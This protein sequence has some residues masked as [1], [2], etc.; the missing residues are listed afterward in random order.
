MA[1][2]FDDAGKQISS[3]AYTQEFMDELEGFMSDEAF[4]VEAYLTERYLAEWE[5]MNAVHERL[6][7]ITMPRNPLY[8]PL[9]MMPAHTKLGQLVDPLSGQPVGSGSMDPSSTLRRSKTAIAEPNF[10]DAFQTFFAHKQQI[11]H[12]MAYAELVKDMQAVLGSRKLRKS[13]EARAGREGTNT[14]AGWIKI[15]AEDGIKDSAVS[16][17]PLR[18]LSNMVNRGAQMALVGRFSVMVIQQTQIMAGSLVMPVDAYVKRLALLHAGQL[19][20]AAAYNSDYI[21]RRRKAAPPAVRMAMDQMAA[22]KPNLMKYVA[23]RAGDGIGVADAVFTA[24]TYAILYDYHLSQGKLENLSDAD[25]E[26]QAHLMAEQLV[27]QVAQPVR[28]GTRS[29]FENQATNPVMKLI[30]AFS[31][32]PRQ[33]IV[34][35]A[36]ILQS[37]RPIAEKLKVLSVV[38]AG[39]G[40]MAAILRAMVADMRDD[41]DDELFDNKHWNVERLTLQALTEPISGVPIVGDRIKGAIFNGAR[42]LGMNP[43]FNPD[44]DMLDSAGRAVPAA[45]DLLTLES[46]ESIDD[47]LKDVD[48]VVSGAALFNDNAA[49]ASSFTHL[50]RDVYRVGKNV[51][52]D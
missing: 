15:F 25:A 50:I 43:G 40:G 12:W 52:P 27:E 49:A 42:E 29:L 45:A 2:R 41:D 7:G 28:P 19:E 51:A 14:L 9:T 38:F 48:A 47:L 44:G 30:W 20:W 4:A 22:G 18:L 11:E 33:K 10:L 3:W 46:F 39:M 31:S 17:G 5:E 37:N 23:G 26:A 36:Y 13:V 35:A 6:F 34:L 1:G 24:G 32:D 8:S 21:Q 16:T